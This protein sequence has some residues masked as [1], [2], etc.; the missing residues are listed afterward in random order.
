ML[1]SPLSQIHPSRRS[2]KFFPPTVP[3]ARSTV[4]APEPGDPAAYLD[5][6]SKSWELICCPAW[7]STANTSPQRYSR[8]T[9]CISLTGEGRNAWGCRRHCP[10]PCGS[11]GSVGR[12]G[13]H[14]DTLLPRALGSVWMGA[15]EHRVLSSTKRHVHRCSGAGTQP[16]EQ[17]CTI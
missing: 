14:G 10:S 3:P 11:P 4:M 8:R 15:R 12:A 9:V 16:Q 7:I 17:V 5:R 1:G 2:P 13:S 6:S